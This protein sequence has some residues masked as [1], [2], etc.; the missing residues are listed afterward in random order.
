MEGPGVWR[1]VFQRVPTEA[2]L[3]QEL[4]QCVV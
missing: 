4:I 3:G 1:E 2:E